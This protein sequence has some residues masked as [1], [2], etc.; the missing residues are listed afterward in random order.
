MNISVERLIANGFTVDGEDYMCP[1]G[2]SFREKFHN[3]RI[4]EFRVNK[5]KTSYADL[6]PECK[7]FNYLQAVRNQ[8]TSFGYVLIS[9]IPR[10]LDLRK[11][12]ISIRCKN[13]H[14]EHRKVENLRASP[15]CNKCRLSAAGWYETT[16]GLGI[17]LVEKTGVNKAKLLLPG[18]LV[19][20][21]LCEISE[22]YTLDPY[23]MFSYIKGELRREDERSDRSRYKT[24]CTEGHIFDSSRRSLLEGHGC[25]L[26]SLAKIN[27]PEKIIGSWVEDIGIP[28]IRREPSAIGIEFDI[29]VPDRMI[30]I[31][32]CGIRWHSLESASMTQKKSKEKRLKEFPYKHQ[33]KTVLAAQHGIHLVTVF[34]SEFLHNRDF[35][36]D[37]V[38]DALTGIDPDT[39]DLRYRKLLPDSRYTE[40]QPLY[41]NRSY[42][43]LDDSEFSKYT[44][45]D[46]GNLIIG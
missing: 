45:Y 38:L 35:V 27:E 39:N 31:E 36:K 29:F 20:M 3:M 32:Y 15:K 30:A 6:C 18:G 33:R 40:P 42:K 24:T 8:I 37:R 2:H 4:R 46:C 44:V 14:I 23:N 5:G 13:G 25:R 17:P 34:E 41:F 1:K 22:R 9:D 10:D 43:Q 16:K 19:D 21:S 11:T 28:I 26:C 12:S 7:N